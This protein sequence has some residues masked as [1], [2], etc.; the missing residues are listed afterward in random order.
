MNSN[1]EIL[2]IQDHYFKN[3][4]SKPVKLLIEFSKCK[5]IKQIWS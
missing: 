5:E 1:T 3:W 4:A 2:V